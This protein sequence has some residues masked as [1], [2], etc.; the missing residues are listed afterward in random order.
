MQRQT[1]SVTA[2]AAS[3][4]LITENYISPFNIGFAVVVTGT[5]TYSVQHSFDDPSALT[6]WFNHPT[7]NGQ[8]TNQDGNYAFPVTA[9]RVNATAGTGTAT[10]S[11]VQAGHVA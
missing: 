6:D 4:P 3:S 5:I 8:T 10:L 2:V 9:I 1:T 11:M 7:I